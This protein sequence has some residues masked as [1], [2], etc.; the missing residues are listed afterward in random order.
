MNV[1]GLKFQVSNIS[2]S[3]LKKGALLIILLTAVSV[4]TYVANELM[5]WDIP[6]F[7]NWLAS[8]NW[9]IQ[10]FC[11]VQIYPKL[12][13]INIAFVLTCKKALKKWMCYTIFTTKPYLSNIFVSELKILKSIFTTLQHSCPVQI[14][15]IKAQIKHFN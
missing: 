6:I 1:I 4:N 15:W 7:H 8:K 3:N 10:H 14:I 9:S 13:K 5:T 11:A 2:P 12:Y